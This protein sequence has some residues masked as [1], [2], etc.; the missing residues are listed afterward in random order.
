M[1]TIKQV[2]QSLLDSKKNI[3]YIE[4]EYCVCCQEFSR[5]TR[6]SYYYRYEK[7]ACIVTA[8]KRTLP[9]DEILNPPAGRKALVKGLRGEYYDSYPE[10]GVRKREYILY[11]SKEACPLKIK[12]SAGS[13]EG[14][15]D[16]DY[17]SSDSDE[18]WVTYLSAV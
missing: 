17:W 1:N 2:V 13:G 8:D 11:I 9:A 14:H 7:P 15:K 6:S 5:D 4:E 18:Y 10:D 12:Y 16:S 3:V